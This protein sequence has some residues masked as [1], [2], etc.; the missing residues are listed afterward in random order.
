M[1]PAG[2]FRSEAVNQHFAEQ[3]VLIEHIPGESHWQISAVERAIQTTKN[4]MGK[5]ALEFPEMSC[6][7]IFLKSIWAQNIRDQYMGFSP[8]QHA[9]G[10][11]PDDYEHIHKEGT[12][13]FPIITEKGIS[14]E[15]GNDQKSHANCR[16][17]FFE[18]TVQPETSEGTAFGLKKTLSL[19]ARETWFFTGENR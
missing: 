19:Q 5:L 16:G 7:E 9:M 4:M 18:R 14:A 12:K 10:R 11:N 2:G 3:K 15:F 17:G 6:R 13:D 1:D 8:L